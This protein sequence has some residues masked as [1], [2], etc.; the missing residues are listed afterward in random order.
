MSVICLGTMTW[1]EQNTEGEAFEQM[2]YALDHGVNF[3]DTA[4]MY[5]VPA[6]E[7]KMGRTEEH[8]GAWLAARGRRDRVVLAT[9]VAGPSSMTRPGGAG[10]TMPD[11]GQIFEAIE[12]SLRRLRTDYVDLYQVH[13]PARKTNYFGTVR[14][15][16]PPEGADPVAIEET[17]G[18]IGDLVDQGKVRAFGVSNETPWGMLE[19]LRLA[20]DKGLPRVAS[21]Q[22]PYNLLNR[23]YEFGMAEISHRERCGLLAYS[24]LG[25]G[26][27]SG[28][29][30]DGARPEGCRLTMWG[31]YFSRYL[32]DRMVEKTRRHVDLAREHGL[33]PAQMAI[34]FTLSR[35]FL[36]SSI[37]GATTM[38]QLRSNIAAAQVTLDDGLAGKINDLAD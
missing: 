35:K 23:N 17:L 37:I 32:S 36:T 24:P 3:L 22:N 5:P 2:D 28:K 18:A 6:D 30:L 38:E 33:D 26:V 21:V 15:T 16:D 25:F 19:Y 13:W 29:Y 14:Y 1:G 4:E 7:K 9:K 27:L 12:G 20:R 10:P 11:R 8:I 31:K 34:A